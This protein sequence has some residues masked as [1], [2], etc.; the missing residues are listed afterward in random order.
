MSAAKHTPAEFPDYVRIEGVL[1]P[2]GSIAERQAR[3]R[4][5]APDLYE[6]LREI[7]DGC[8]VRRPGHVDYARNRTKEQIGEIARAA[9]AKVS[10]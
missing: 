8:I 10:P 6:A 5:A 9:L 7:A 4:A 3:M 2:R 1:I